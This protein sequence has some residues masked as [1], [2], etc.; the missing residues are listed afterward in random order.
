M[1]SCRNTL[2]S[3]KETWNCSKVSGDNHALC[4]LK[5]FDEDSIGEINCDL[6]GSQR[7]IEFCLEQVQQ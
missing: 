5:K 1:D 7:Q 4:D 6:K 2:E 3:E